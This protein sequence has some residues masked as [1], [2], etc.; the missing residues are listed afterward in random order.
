MGI[1]QY[2]KFF[3]L[4]RYHSQLFWKLQSAVAVYTARL[5]HAYTNEFLWEL[6]PCLLATFPFHEG[7][8]LPREIRSWKGVHSLVD[9][10]WRPGVDWPR[11]EVQSQERVYGIAALVMFCRPNEAGGEIICIRRGKRKWKGN[12]GC[13]TECWKLSSDF[14]FIKLKEW[15][16]VI[17]T[18]QFIL[19]WSSMQ[20]T[21]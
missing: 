17:R 8:S 14:S 9:W 7:R 6:E 21:N 15:S 11:L 16:P 20:T 19:T 4:Y 18:P 5:C 12:L 1:L 10:K 13:G 2:V 3:V